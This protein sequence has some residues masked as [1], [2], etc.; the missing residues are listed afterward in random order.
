MS[1]SPQCS[2]TFFWCVL[3]IHI[4]NSYFFIC[5]FS[6]KMIFFKTMEKLLELNKLYGRKTFHIIHQIKVYHGYRL[7]IAC[8]PL[9]PKT[10]RIQ[11]HLLKLK[12]D[13]FFRTNS[14]I[15]IATWNSASL[16]CIL[17]PNRSRSSKC[18]SLW[19]FRNAGLCT[20]NRKLRGYLG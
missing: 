13:L 15:W 17:G 6:S 12:M 2:Q 7:W 1:D 19:I 5:G 4:K 16:R 18:I 8:M 11:I 3:E 9:K 20:E 14:W 10:I